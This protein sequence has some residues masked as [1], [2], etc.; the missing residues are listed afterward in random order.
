MTSR[1]RLVRSTTLYKGKVVRLTVDEVV[2]PGGVNARR[3]VVRH[4]AS[5]VVLPHLPDGR[6]LLVRQYRHAAHQSLWE[7]VAGTLE[8][9]E[10]PLEAARRE[11]LE[12]T[13]YHARTLKPLFD[14]FPSPGFLSEQMHL[15][16]ARGLSR[17][18]ARPDAD[19]RIRIRRFTRGQLGKMLRAKK[20]RDGKTL[21]GLLW[22]LH[23][24]HL[25]S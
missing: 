1:A 3:E 11:L 20:I 21:V 14:F 15:F 5:V 17:T 12:E 23:P 4:S 10:N 24:F 8:P 9:G 25:R 7:L 2:E 6:V 19:E 18:K 13:G 22:L 16:E